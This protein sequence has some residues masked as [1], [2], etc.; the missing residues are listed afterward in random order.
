VPLRFPST[1]KP[2]IAHENE[3]AEQTD[4]EYDEDA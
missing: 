2:A 1:L 4:D 3:T